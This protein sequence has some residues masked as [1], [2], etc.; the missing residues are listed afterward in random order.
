MMKR[1]NIVLENIGMRLTS[2][3]KIAYEGV[4]EKSDFKSACIA[5]LLDKKASNEDI[6]QIT[7][8]LDNNPVLTKREVLAFVLGDDT[9]LNNSLIG[10]Y[11][12][13]ENPVLSAYYR[14]V[15]EGE[16]AF[17]L[18]ASELIMGN[19]LKRDF[20]S[21]Q[22]MY[23]NAYFTLCGLSSVEKYFIDSKLTLEDKIKQKI[24]LENEAVNN[25]ELMRNNKLSLTQMPHS[26]I[27]SNFQL[28]NKLLCLDDNSNSQSTVGLPKI[29][30]FG[31]IE[32]HYNKPQKN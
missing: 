17:Q 13:F 11:K 5:Y 15:C 7:Q 14:G 4:K 16:V 25:T 27:H 32:H 10:L 26:I 24:L 6:E 3:S 21:S 23:D 19:L 20:F 28:L 29:N 12:S 31:D 9:N 8:I 30:R 2:S 22:E 18:Q 1:N